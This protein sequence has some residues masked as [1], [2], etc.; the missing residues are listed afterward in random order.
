MN[1]L[2]E[3]IRRS[4]PG[5]V[6]AALT[7]IACSTADAAVELLGVQYQQDNPYS[8]FSCWYHYGNYPTSCGTV[9]TGC[10]V[11]VF[12]KN[13]GPSSVTINNV[14]LA[15]Y[16]LSTILKR[17]A[18]FHDANSIYFYWDDPPQDIFD[19]GEPVWFRLDPNPIP[20]GGVARVVVRLRSVPVTRPVSLAVATTAG[21]V[22]ANIPVNASDPVLASV[23]FSADRTKVYLHW[24]RSGGAAP[25]SVW[26]DGSNV[27][28]LTTTVGDS[29]VN[30]AASVIQLPTPL[31]NMSYHVYQGVYADGKTATG[32]LRTWTNRFI[33]GT[34][35]AK[36]IPDGDTA[37][38][39]AW[40]DGCED[41]GVNAVIMNMASGGLADF[42]GTSAGRDYAEAHNYG[43]VKDDNAW[44]TNPRMWFIDDEPDIEEG[45]IDC[46]VN[47]RI[48]CGGGHT[49]GILGLHMLEYGETLRAMNPSAPTTINLDGNFKPDGWYAY[50]QLADVMMMDSY[51]EQEMAGNHWY[52][53]ERDPLYTKPTSIYAAAIA[54]TT[55]A[56]PNPMHMILYSCEYKDTSLGLIWPFP[57]PASKRIQ[58]Y[59]ALAGGA[60]GMAYWWY[61]SGYPFNGLND[62]GPEAQALWKEIGLVGNDIKAVQ[63]LL[64]ISH[65]VTTPL[66]TSSG[67]WAKT[68]AAG[69]DSM[70]VLAVNDQFYNDSTGTHLTPVSGATATVTLPSWLQPSPTAFEIT[71]GG[72]KPVSTQVV[73]SQLQLNLGTLQVTKMIVLTRD[74]RLLST[75]QR[76]FDT[77]CRPG[78]CAFASESCTNIPLAIAQQPANLVLSPGGSGSFTVAAFGT[79]LTYQWQKNLGNLADGGH[80]SGCT[81]ATLTVAGADSGDVASYRCVVTTSYASS[82]SSPASLTLT[83]NLPA[84]PVANPATAVS[85][86]RFTA[87]WSSADSAAGYRLDVSTNSGFGTFVSGYQDADAGN[88]LSWNVSG[89]NAGTTYYYRVRAYNGNGTSGNSGTISVTLPVPIT[90]PPTGLVNADFEGGNTGGV[91]NGWTGYQRSP[92]ALTTWI[93]QTA[94]PP[95]GGGLQYQQIANTNTAG[96]GG[97]RQNITGCVIGATYTISGWMRGNSGQYSTCQVKVS[98]TASTDWGSAVDLSPA[99]S[100]TGDT[101]TWFSGSVVAAG[102]NMTLWLDGQTTGTAQFK[103]ECFDSITVS[104]DMTAVAP[105]ITQQPSNRSVAEGAST[106]F[107]ITVIGDGH[108]DYRWQKNTANL[109]DGGHYSGAA[110]ATL[111]IIGADSADAA[112]YRCI[113]T[114]AF[115]SVTSSPATL[116]V[117]T[118]GVAPTI[119]QQPTNQGVLAGATAAFAL[120]ASGTAPLAYRWQKNSANLTEGGHYSGTPTPTLTITGADSADVATY[121]CVVTNAYGNATSS[122]VTLTLVTNPVQ[123]FALAQIPTLAGDTTNDA[124]AITPDGRWIVGVS[125]SRGFLYGVGSASAVNVI[126]SDS[127]QSTLLTGIGYRTNSGQQQLVA[128]GLAGGYFTTFMTADGGA[129]WGAKVQ[130]SGTGLKKPTVPVA[131]A[132]AG[133]A[134]DVYYT[135]WTDEGT[136][137]TDNWGLYVGRG[138]NTW[139]ASVGWAPKSATK[140]STLQLNGISANGR[141]VGWRQN[142]GTNINYITDWQG[143][144]TPAIWS[145]NGLD[146]TT[147]GQAY[148]VSADGTIILGVSPR[149]GGTIATNYGYKAVFNATFPGAATQLSIGQLPNFPDTAGA[150]NLAIPYGCTADGK[151]AVGMSYRG[152]ERAVLWDTSDPNPARWTVVDLTDVAAAKGVLGS[153]SRLTRAYS[154]GV[155][156]AGALVIAG[157]GKDPTGNSRGFVATVTP[158]VASIAFPPIVTIAESYTSGF[159]CSFWSPSNAAMTCYLEF[160]TSLVPFSPWGTV[161]STPSIGGTISLSDPNPPDQQ[162]FYRIRI[163]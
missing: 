80:Y 17:N 137:S 59:Y 8:E 118:N 40:I 102:T 144:T 41:R 53:P 72:L 155:N 111:T 19:A 15:G 152:A 160:T 145:P 67:V 127:A 76:R 88:A 43:Y 154:I 113:V 75:L 73:G 49:T 27:T 146:G 101:W 11:H 20:A 121:R 99:A 42:L 108:L 96:G 143:A 82:N 45:N 105:S 163:R 33:Y 84:I 60:K 37:G 28:S 65:P 77:V 153:F 55:A 124:R 3:L 135:V 18:T 34:W 132:L 46:G 138:S 5:L 115:G 149:A 150:T 119:T 24:R 52:H 29:A 97:V 68:L 74:P 2:K 120:Q 87:N 50:G 106:N 151:F 89:L 128:A 90:C 6:A 139:P 133:A 94:G 112:T 10:N 142:S 103:A 9:I 21:T 71:S 48:P 116:V 78:I 100:Y 16:N 85:T 117:T 136:N 12:L 107:T 141:G 104:C 23:G 51:Y 61:K 110:S 57:T 147:V 30:Y 114:N 22:N 39:Q 7:A 35:A 63:P 91:A 32:S 47:L 161:T 62:G 122:P 81:N 148:A 123:D 83:T 79:G 95:T 92:Y 31:A 38:A 56:E 26:L 70:I 129:T 14:T 156:A 69:V 66:A 162:G 98:P 125:G 25:A 58:A 1:T 44:G 158:P 86:N 64:V 140:P 130:Y 134:S 93:I 159:T 126:S 157:V 4:S 131:N 109:S 54:T 13:T 36:E